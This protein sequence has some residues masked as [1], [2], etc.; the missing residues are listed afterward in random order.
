[1]ARTLI[2]VS[3]VLGGGHPVLLS[4]HAAQTKPTTWMHNSG[5]TIQDV[6]PAVLPV[7][8]CR[9]FRCSACCAHLTLPLLRLLCSPPPAAAP[10]AALT[11]C[12]RCSACCAC[13]QEY[14]KQ[15]IRPALLSARPKNTEY[16]CPYGAKYGE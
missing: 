9:H 3:A 6:P 13:L 8:A 14:F 5:R 7:D 11:S 15:K 4:W 12:R 10:P 2:D 1:M 16:G